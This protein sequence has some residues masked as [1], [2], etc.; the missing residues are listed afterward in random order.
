[1]KK[2]L[3]ILTVLAIGCTITGLTTWNS[4]L[5]G[6]KGETAIVPDFQGLSVAEAIRIATKK[7]IY[8][9]VNEK[10]RVFS[11]FINKNHIAA[12]DPSQ[13]KIIKQ[14]RTI[15]VILSNGS[16]AETIPDLTGK[17]LEQA[18]YE[19][20]RKNLRLVDITYVHN[21]KPEGIVI[22]QSP[23]PHSL[24]LADSRIKLLTSKSKKTKA[25]I[26]PDLRLFTLVK[27]EKKLRKMNIKYII[28]TFANQIEDRNTLFVK[29][30]FPAP[31]FCL[32]DNDII[33]LRV[34]EREQL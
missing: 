9:K 22:A 11:E 5:S 32:N 8:I 17:K 31:G 34:E 14:S 1:M 18:S 29:E 24:G 21:S 27:V 20:S 19:I 13:G 6:V 25:Y 4:L 7:G 30:Q 28:K 15:E 12:Q 16:K 10:R 2:I 3:I 26:M 23:K 33:T